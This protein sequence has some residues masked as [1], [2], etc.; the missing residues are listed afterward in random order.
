MSPLLHFVDMLMLSYQ[1]LGLAT[2][3]QS[4]LEY[5]VWGHTPHKEHQKIPN[6][7]GC[8]RSGGLLVC[9]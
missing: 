3:I 7:Y 5:E 1:F 8:E 2:G 4:T 6:F 9:I